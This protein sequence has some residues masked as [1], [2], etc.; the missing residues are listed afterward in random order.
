MEARI[1]PQPDYYKVRH[2]IH[3]MRL[4]ILLDVTHNNHEK[5]IAFYSSDRANEMRILESEIES[6]LNKA[7]LREKLRRQENILEEEIL[8][9]RKK[10]EEIEKRHQED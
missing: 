2:F 7:S 4:R 10:L 3:V 8:H 6:K 5:S 1:S 9:A